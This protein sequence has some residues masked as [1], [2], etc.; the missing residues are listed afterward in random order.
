MAMIGIMM[1]YGGDWE[2][3]VELT[4]RA[5]A[6]NSNHPGWYR[7]NI[8]F[9]QYRQESYAKA[10]DTAQRINMPGYFAD[11]YARAI[12]HAQLGHRPEAAEAM[13][14]LRALWPGFDLK[15][16]KEGHLDIW[17]FAQPE[18]IEQV[19]DGLRKADS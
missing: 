13:K 15:S 6:L 9:N 14:E 11:P 10:L 8:F 19:L 7:F 1:G 3:S 17:F 2:R 18:L 16:F 4:R 12:A 5:M